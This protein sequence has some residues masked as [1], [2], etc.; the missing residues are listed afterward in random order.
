MKPRRG[1]YWADVPALP[2]C[3][4]AGDTL[5][6]LLQDVQYAIESYLSALDEEQET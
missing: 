4:G 6:E 5:D 3:F 1:G 2:G